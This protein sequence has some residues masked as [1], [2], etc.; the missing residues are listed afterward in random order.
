MSESP[1]ASARTL[2]LLAAGV[3]AVLLGLFAA[4]E[5]LRGHAPRTEAATVLD[6]ARPLPPFELVAGDGARFDRSRLLRHYTFVFFGFSNCPDVCPTTLAEL[7]IARRALEDLPEPRRPAVVMIGVDPG[8]D[9]PV[10]LARYVAHFDPAFTAA[11]GAEA[12]LG[13]LAAALGAAFETA[14]ATDGSY[15]VEHTAIVFL[16]DPDAALVAVFPAPQVARTL[17]ADYRSI[18]AARGPT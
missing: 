17:A 16:V 10:S 5:A 3:A 4:R 11:T 15:R 8:R 1:R 13:R 2:V 18:A 9:T 7:A 14:P 12:E 6:R